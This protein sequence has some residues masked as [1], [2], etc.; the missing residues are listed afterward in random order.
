M[1]DSTITGDSRTPGALP[2]SVHMIGI[3]GAG[4]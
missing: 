1:S 3:G 4:M 2:A